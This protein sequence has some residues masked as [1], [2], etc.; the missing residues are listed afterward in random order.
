[1]LKRSAQEAKQETVVGI[2]R[3]WQEE[4]VHIKTKEWINNWCLGKKNSS[5]INRSVND[6]Q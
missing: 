4:T 6:I 5:K 1:M 3:S 2:T